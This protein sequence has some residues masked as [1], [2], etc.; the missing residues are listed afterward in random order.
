MALV[1][2]LK[3]LLGVLLFLCGLVLGIWF[4]IRYRRHENA[5]LTRLAP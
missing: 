1:T 2:F 3:A 5:G 4:I